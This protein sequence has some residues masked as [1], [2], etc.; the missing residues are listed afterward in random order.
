[1]DVEHVPDHLV[2]PGPVV[3]GVRR[4]VDP[5]EAAARLDVAL[6]RGLLLVVEDVAR[7]AQEDHHL[8]LLELLVFEHARGV[9]GPEHVEV[10]QLRRGADRFDAFEM[11]SWCQ[12]AVFENSSTLNCSA[13]A[14]RGEA[15][16]EWKAGEG[17]GA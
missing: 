9:F 15:S 5:D 3:F 7:G 11:D 13:W 10:V 16:R 4:G 14:A 8:V 17:G 2:V 6:E 1:M 12:P